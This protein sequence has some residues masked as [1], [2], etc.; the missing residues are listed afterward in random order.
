MGHKVWLDL[1][2]G[3]AVRGGQFGSLFRG[4]YETGLS[5]LLGA[6]W[7]W[8]WWSAWLVLFQDASLGS[9][10]LPRPF[11]LIISSVS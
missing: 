3:L 1:S 7:W 4:S 6:L 8:W 2:R 11:S 5:S 9:R 10:E